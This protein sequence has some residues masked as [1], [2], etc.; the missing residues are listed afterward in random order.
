MQWVEPSGSE[1]NDQ[2]S[3]EGPAVAILKLVPA[4]AITSPGQLR[5]LNQTTYKDYTHSRTFFIHI[6]P[7]AAGAR[8]P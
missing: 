3:G 6:A 7:R 5:K 4:S 8:W 2:Q 1:L